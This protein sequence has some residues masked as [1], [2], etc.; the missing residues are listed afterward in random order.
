MHLMITLSSW[1]AFRTMTIPVF[2]SW[3]TV[4][5]KLFKYDFGLFISLSLYTV[6]RATA[7]NGSL[8]SFTIP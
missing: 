6:L 3:N 5:S 7:E 4:Y 2:Q 8:F 1:K